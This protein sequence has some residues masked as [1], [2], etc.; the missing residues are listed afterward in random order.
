ML[1]VRPS[2]TKPREYQSTLQDFPAPQPKTATRSTKAVRPAFMDQEPQQSSRWHLRLLSEDGPLCG[3]SARPFASENVDPPEET[4]ARIGGLAAAYAE[5]QW[6]GDNTWSPALAAFANACLRTRGREAA[7][8]RRR[9]P[10][11]PKLHWVFRALLRTFLAQ[12]PALVTGSGRLQ[13]ANNQNLSF[14]RLHGERDEEHPSLAALFFSRWH[15]RRSNF[16]H[17][18]RK[19]FDH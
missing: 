8:A 4:I 18:R 14:I 15:A 10:G 16:L 7:A 11:I 5:E 3:C 19:F 1:T 17:A 2:I 6:K 13:A 12:A 9:F